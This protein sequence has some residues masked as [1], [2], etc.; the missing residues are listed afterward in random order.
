MEVIPFFSLSS[1]RSFGPDGKAFVELTAWNV[2]ALEFRVYRVHD[3]VRFF[4]Q[5]EDAHRFGGTVQRPGSNRSLLERI[6]QWKHELRTQI[7]RS[8]RN[9]FTEPPSARFASFLPSQERTT[10]AERGARFATPPVLN[11]QQ[12]VLKFTQPVQSANRWQSQKVDVAL[13]QKGVFLV[14]AARGDL[15]AY[16]ILVVSD[17][18]LV[19]KVSKGLVTAFVVNRSTGEP[20]PGAEILSMTRNGL[21]HSATTDGDGVA[22]FPMEGSGESDL[23]VVARHA[24]DVA[25]NSLYN[26]GF[27]P[28]DQNWMGYLYT[29]RPVYRPGH[30]VHFKGILRLAQDAGYSIPAGREVLVRITDPSS[31]TV[32]QRSLKTSALGTI[33]DDFTLL[34]NAAV[35]QYYLRVT[36]GRGE[37]GQGFSVQEYKKPEY[38]VRVGPQQPRILQGE[39]VQAVISARYYFG[40]PVSGAKVR[41]AVYRSRYWFPMW[42]DPDEEIPDVEG[43]GDGY[44]GENEQVAN[45]TGT[46]DS[47]GKLTISVL[48]PL[49]NRKEDNRYRIEA[50][51]TDAG[52]REISG[53]GFVVAT[54]GNFALNVAPDR[55]VYE[56]TSKASVTIQ[57]RDYDNLP[58]RTPVR[59]ELLKGGARDGAPQVL[60]TASASTNEDGSV[61]VTLNT[62]ASGGLYRLRATARSG[63]REIEAMGYLWISGD[64]GFNF[65]GRKSVQIVADKKSYRAGD[66]AKLLIIT[67]VANAPVYVTVEGQ[68]LRS[69]KLLRAP[70]GT[71]SFE[72]PITVNDEPGSYVSAQFVRDGEFYQ[73]SKHIKVPPV[74]HTLNVK[75]ATDKPTYRPGETGIYDITVTR[76]DGTPVPRADLSLGVVDEAIY[77]IQRE[78]TTDILR[79]FYGDPGNSVYTES[80]LNFFFS[81]E[82]GKRRMQLA[83]LRPASRLAQLKPDSLVQPKVRKL[84]PDTAFW[85]AE[86]TTDGNGRA[87]AKTPFPD[88]LTTWRATAR[89]I[90]PDNSVGATTL[91]TVVR[92]NLIL[93]LAIPRFLVQGDEVVVSAIVHNYLDAEKKVHLALDVKGADV[94]GGAS[95]DVMVPSRG[96]AHLDWRIRAKA[97]PTVAFEGRALT[98]EESDALQLEI[99]IKPAGV[100]LATSRGGSIRNTGADSFTL[101]FPSHVEPDS[102]SITLRVTPSIAGSLFAALEYLTSYPYGCVEQTM[103]SFLPN[104]VVSKAVSDF[105]L[106]SGMDEAALKEK[107]QTGLDRLYGFQH[108]DGG[109]GWW[110]SDESHPFMTAYV[111]SGLAQARAAGTEI[112]S[113]VVEKG[114]AWLRKAAPDP[115]SAPDLRAYLGFALATAGSSDRALVDAI[116]DGR[117]KLSPYGLALLGLTLETGR[118]SRAAEIAGTLRRVAKEDAEQAWWP[119]ERDE[120][121]DFSADVTPEATA[122]AVRFLSHENVNDPL[123]PKAALWLMNHRNEGY[124][125]SSTKQTAMVIYSLTDYLK[126]SN[127]LNPDLTATVLVNGKAVLTRHLDGPGDSLQLRLDESKL[128]Q[129]EN[130]IRVESSGQGR[131]YYSARG[132]YYSNED[133]LQRTGR[134]SLN[135]LR[136]YFRLLPRKRDDRIVYDLAPLGSAASPGDVIAVRLTVTGAQSKYLFIEDPIPAG[137]EFIER[138]DFYELSNRPPWWEYF[139]TRRELHDDRVAI[140]QTYFPQGQQQYFYLLKVVNPG[141]F[142]ISPARVQPMYQPELFSTTES[143]RLE[144]K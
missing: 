130:Q 131:L 35:G 88:S 137:S 65:G 17:L 119:A 3:P 99:P 30:P 104:I 128:N 105:G 55:Y 144:V 86:I 19:T 40:E 52:K 11:P 103:S 16:T 21:P 136:D 126:S 24:G 13:K 94:L 22:E 108:D 62:P 32:Y 67:G 90:S 27:R 38:E 91:K 57:A 20:I 95:G 39:S 89:A 92:K 1:S 109:W 34:D 28:D 76:E 87:Q 142:R 121:L 101:A 37:M 78:T 46:L 96:E 42:Y 75:L 127:E 51:V 10:V 8:L 80:S 18:A 100:K 143:L 124:W 122:Y 140:F 111:V 125:W 71:V 48:A 47:G 102:R 141:L 56:P 25:L 2:N 66:T 72:A 53:A 77:A 97:A 54:Y 132:D 45:G 117:A 7:R 123:L 85:D 129:T 135:I 43:D 112:R 74:D 68:N 114:I 107:I 134:L 116:Y 64:F 93:R 69:H 31:N 15:Q 4:S 6:H 41:Y 106:R 115:Q 26:Y 70:N 9:Q 81:G 36:S 139:F 5:L 79:F 50:F 29:D 118:D 12:L 120:M 59:V 33:H 133:R 60:T 61:Q 14:E 98:D 23:R 44:Y 83:A 84:F 63:G 110:E 113:G 58:V 49:S 73:G 82:A 138:D